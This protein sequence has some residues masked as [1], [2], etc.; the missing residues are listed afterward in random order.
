MGS[1]ATTG[2]LYLRYESIILG[3]PSNNR[4]HANPILAASNPNAKNADVGST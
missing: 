2:V 1:S 4:I 3:Y